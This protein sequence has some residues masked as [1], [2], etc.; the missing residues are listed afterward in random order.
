MSQN[1]EKY[2]TTAQPID[3]EAG[4]LSNPGPAG[5]GG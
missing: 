1:T 5:G 3:P 2:K 4:S